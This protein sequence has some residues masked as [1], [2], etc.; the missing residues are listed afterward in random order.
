MLGRAIARGLRALQVPVIDISP[1]RTWDSKWHQDFILHLA[2]LFRPNVYVEVGI[3]HCG[4]F[5]R[6]IPYASRL[7]GVDANPDS[8]KYMKRCAKTEFVCA[9]SSDYV[10]RLRQQPLLIDL[11]FIDADHSEAA[12]ESDFKGVFNFVAPHGLILLHDTHPLDERA[13]SQERCGDGY[14]AV[15]RLSARTEQYEMMTLPKHPGLTLCRKRTQQLSWQEQG[16]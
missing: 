12:V 14:K 8:A 10:G 5:N 3:H 6:M 2:S 9:T 1:D 13:T 11:L 16:A 7:I 4:L 15:A